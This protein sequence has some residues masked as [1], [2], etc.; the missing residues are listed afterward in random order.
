M[1]MKFTQRR[2]MRTA[3]VAVVA[4]VAFVG[5]TSLAGSGGD[6]GPQPEV[7]PGVPAG[8]DT[9][10][11]A[12]SA[13]GT[14]A[15][16]TGGTN[17]DAT[18]LTKF[19]PGTGF[20]ANQETGINDDNLAVNG[21]AACVSPGTAGQ[22]TRLWA[23]VE[24]PDGAQ[25]TGVQFLGI[26]NSASFNI[27]TTLLRTSLSFP[28]FGSSSRSDTSVTSFATSGA[29]SLPVAIN[30]SGT[31]AEDVGTPSSGFLFTGENRFHAITVDM[32]NGESHV[33]C[34]V[35]VFYRVPILTNPGVA[36]FPITPFRAFDSR[37]PDYGAAAGILAPGAQK[38]I[39]IADGHDLAT[40]VTN[41]TNLVP[42]GAT[43]ITY[44]ITVTGA[45]GANFVAVTPGD[46]T[47]FGVS[48]INFNGVM[49]VANGA[50][51]GVDASRQIK[52]FGGGG[53]GSVHVIVDVTGYYAP[54]TPPNMGN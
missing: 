29:S 44:N 45:T 5:G 8:Q 43:A 37:D 4:S 22:N 31:L 24:L 25:I 47:S 49:D 50:T 42:T 28:L 23:S 48:T 18:T 9:V 41:A 7:P 54:Y 2:V 32:D 27:V 16:T 51:V 40:G 21:G 3:A 39:S 15:I 17:F 11:D 33:L 26:D 10:G 52:L 1:K 38:T 12:E 30:N 6:H 36:F 53:S 34:G 14:E 19:I 46:A 13:R 20:V 35:K